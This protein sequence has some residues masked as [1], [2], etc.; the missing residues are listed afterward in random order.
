M[1]AI[2]KNYRS[3]LDNYYAN[4]RAVK[5]TVEWVEW[6]RWLAKLNRARRTGS[7]EPRPQAVTYTFDGEPRSFT[8]G[9]K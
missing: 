8:P 7:N 5:V 4:S 6:I 3:V 2:L 1:P 9:A